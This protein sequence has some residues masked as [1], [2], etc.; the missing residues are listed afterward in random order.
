LPW[1]YVACTTGR[2]FI[3]VDDETGAMDRLWADASRSGPSLLHRVDPAKGLT[4]ADF[5]ALADCLRLVIPR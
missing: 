2:P 1:V 5:T 4:D 3:R